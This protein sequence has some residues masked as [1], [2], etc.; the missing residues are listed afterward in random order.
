MREK[1]CIYVC[2]WVTLLY[3]KKLTE[4][5]KPTIMEK[6]KI[7]LKK[8]ENGANPKKEKQDSDPNAAI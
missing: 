5:Y 1:E 4:H 7:I 8:K 3:S 2:D 6:M